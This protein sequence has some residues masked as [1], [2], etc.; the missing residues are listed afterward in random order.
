MRGVLRSFQ[1][2]KISWGSKR[3]QQKNKFIP[4][5]LLKFHAVIFSLI[6][7]YSRCSPAAILKLRLEVIL[8]AGVITSSLSNRVP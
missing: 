7:F 4:E 1:E 5:A 3:W 8:I 6:H 2:G